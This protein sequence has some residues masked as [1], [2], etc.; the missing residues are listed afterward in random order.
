M[1][2]TLKRGLKDL[3]SLESKESQKQFVPDV[4]RDGQ[5]LGQSALQRLA[6]RSGCL[7]RYFSGAKGKMRSVL[8]ESATQTSGS[9]IRAA[10]QSC[11]FGLRSS[12]TEILPK[13]LRLTRLET[14]TKEFMKYTSLRVQ[15]PIR[16]NESKYK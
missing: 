7:Q 10:E 6:V 13:R 5:S 16:R 4:W 14:R 3:K 9:L 15:K 2:R 1:K 8:Q 12:I 11:R